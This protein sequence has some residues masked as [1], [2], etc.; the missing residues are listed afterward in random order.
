M[1]RTTAPAA[2]PQPFGE[3]FAADPHAVH[4]RLRAAGPV[5][6]VALPDGSPVWLVTREA[7]VRHGLADPRLSVDKRHAGGDFKGFS[8]PRPWTRTC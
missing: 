8:L 7:D 4:A 1:T 5:H 3:A 6:R 2:L